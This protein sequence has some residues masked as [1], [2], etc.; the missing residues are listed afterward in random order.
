MSSEGLEVGE[1]GAIRAR[2]LSEACRLFALKGFSATSIREITQAVGVTNPMVYYYFGNK[3][4]LFLAVLEEAT[5][6]VNAG[7]AAIS[8]QDKPFD[9]ALV[10]LILL[11]FGLIKESPDVARLFLYLQY[12]HERLRF[13]D[14]FNDLHDK[15]KA[16]WRGLLLRGI[17]RGEVSVADV[18]LALLQIFGLI[19]MPMLLFLSGEP[20]S[21][22][23]KT[24]RVLVKQLMDGV[25]PR[26]IGVEV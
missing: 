19:H 11:Y 15:G 7:V 16:M 25:R 13:K 4:D 23:V 1:K 3:E 26:P 2:L 9:E 8:A 20:V 5:E 21:L 6:A 22:D 18:D 24:A 14:A 12:G 10:A 17:E